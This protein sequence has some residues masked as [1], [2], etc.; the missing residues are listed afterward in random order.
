MIFYL[1]IFGIIY[2]IIAKQCQKEP[3]P[4]KQKKE[5]Q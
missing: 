4:L 5:L 1:Y 3:V 2:I